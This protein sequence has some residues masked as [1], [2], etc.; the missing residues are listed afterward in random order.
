MKFISKHT[1]PLLQEEYDYKNVQATKNPKILRICA[2]WEFR[3]YSMISSTLQVH[4]TRRSPLPPQGRRYH[5]P[6]FMRH[7]HARKCQHMLH[8]HARNCQH[9]YVQYLPTLVRFIFKGECLAT[10]RISPFTHI[11]PREVMLGT[12]T[13]LQ[14]SG[15][16]HPCGCQCGKI[17]K[18]GQSPTPLRGRNPMQCTS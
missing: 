4:E 13:P 16:I 1:V 18:N 2:A 3:P 6:C 10:L 5:A 15:H 9:M 17:L 8:A 11:P 12:T 14:N 7:S